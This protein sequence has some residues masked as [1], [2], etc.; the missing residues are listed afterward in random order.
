MHTRLIWNWYMY[1]YVF[2]YIGAMYISVHVYDILHAILSEVIFDRL[3]QR[4]AIVYE[5]IAN[6]SLQ[7]ANM[8]SH[9]RQYWAV[10][11]TKNIP[12]I[13]HIP[14]NMIHDSSYVHVLVCLWLYRTSCCRFN[15]WI[16]VYCKLLPHFIIFYSLY[17]SVL[18]LY[19]I[20]VDCSI[21][22]GLVSHVPIQ[23]SPS[24]Y[25]NIYW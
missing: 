6:I 10:I 11:F 2:M 8:S 3:K 17:L 24:I 23:P 20:L 21:G 16:P 1:T 18:R 5:H 25:L 4:T 15:Y 7:F 13:P 12:I 9:W 14:T 19:T 22:R